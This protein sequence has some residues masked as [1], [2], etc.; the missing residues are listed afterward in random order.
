MI[1]ESVSLKYE[2]ASVTA[3]HFCEG[4]VLKLRTRSESGALRTRSE[5]GDMSQ[6]M[7]VVMLRGRYRETWLIRKRRLGPYNRTMPRVLWSEGGRRFLMSE[8]P[9]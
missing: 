3:T 2:P 5:S 9:L 1:Q 8:V 6:G 4:V 7:S